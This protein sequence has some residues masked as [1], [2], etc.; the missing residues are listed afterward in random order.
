MEQ[1]SE[2]ISAAEPLRRQSQGRWH[3]PLLKMTA[4]WQR[5]GACAPGAPRSASGTG[6]P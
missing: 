5:E 3:H 6:T 4:T 1:I 2:V